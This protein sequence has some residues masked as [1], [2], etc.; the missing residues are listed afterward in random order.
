[1][2]LFPPRI[3]IILAFISAI[4]FLTTSFN[5]EACLSVSPAPDA[6]ASVN[7]AQPQWAWP[8][9]QPRRVARPFDPPEFPWLS[10]HR[11]VDLSVEIGADILAVAPGVVIYAGLLVD[12]PVISIQHDNGLRS[13][14]EPVEPLIS[15]GDIVT[16]GQIIGKLV[17]G[18]SPG[19]LHW[20]AKVDADTYVDPLGLVFGPVSLKPWDG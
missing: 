1:M 6:V 14:F 18:H 17:E 20:G 16:T 19:S 2:R 7:L 11:G 4:S 15:V 9:G 13:T 3:G 8:T 10:G 12:R 5:A